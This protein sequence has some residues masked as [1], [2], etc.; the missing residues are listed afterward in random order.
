M[1]HALVSAGR[2][3]YLLVAI[4]LCLNLIIARS[5]FM[6]FEGAIRRVRQALVI[7]ISSMLAI[8]LWAGVRMTVSVQI[9]VIQS[10]NRPTDYDWAIVITAACAALGILLLSIFRIGRHTCITMSPSSKMVWH[11]GE[12]ISIEAY[13]SQVMRVTITHSMTS[14]EK[15]EALR[16][17]HEDI[18]KSGV[19]RPTGH[20]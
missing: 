11:K 16:K 6:S 19:P 15:E 20:D 18:A 10:A 7:I 8:L 13:L 4:L 5:L 1:G 9:D 17:Y 12:W 14:E 2:M 3:E